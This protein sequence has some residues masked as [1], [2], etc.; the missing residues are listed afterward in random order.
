MSNILIE[1]RCIQIKPHTV[2]VYMKVTF[3]FYKFLRKIY[4]N[5]QMSSTLGLIDFWPRSHEVTSRKNRGQ[6]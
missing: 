1:Y 2:K 3:L 4:L 5:I 6:K